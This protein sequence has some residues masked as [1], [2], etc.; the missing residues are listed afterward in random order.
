MQKILAPLI[1]QRAVQQTTQKMPANTS[2]SNVHWKWLL[3]G[4]QYT[5]AEHPLAVLPS[6]LVNHVELL[7]HV[8]LICKCNRRSFQILW[9][10]RSLAVNLNQRAFR[11][12]EPL[13]SSHGSLSVAETSEMVFFLH[14]SQ[15]RHT[16]D[17][18]TWLGLWGALNLPN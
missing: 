13:T 18:E 9:G 2:M 12:M 4:V 8:T 5:P 15:R 3:Y 16:A 11:G 6:L 10:C 17:A 1:K 14:S 7:D